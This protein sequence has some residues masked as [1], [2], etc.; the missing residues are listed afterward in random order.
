MTPLYWEPDLLTLERALIR[1]S[2]RFE[3]RYI[4]TT[5]ERLLCRAHPL[6]G[7]GDSQGRHVYRPIRPR[8]DGGEE[9]R[10]RGRESVRLEGC[11]CP[12]RGRQRHLASQAAD[13]A[14]QKPTGDGDAVDRVP[15]FLRP[16]ERNAHTCDTSGASGELQTVSW[17]SANSISTVGAAAKFQHPSAVIGPEAAFESEVLSA[18]SLRPE[19][20]HC[21]AL[22]MAVEPTC[23]LRP[24]FKLRS[25]AAGN[26]PA[27]PPQTAFALR[28]CNTRPR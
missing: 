20:A 11:T 22:P 5:I 21:D 15:P 6:L 9:V 8:E 27:P 19:R 24:H 12:E 16:C 2:L 17:R 7:R 25:P 10:N 26:C 28:H 14:E 18:L 1:P 23:N 3:R 13:F 4:C